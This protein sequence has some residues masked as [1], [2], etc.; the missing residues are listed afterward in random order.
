MVLP[1]NQDEAI[2]RFSAAFFLQPDE[3]CVLEPLAIKRKGISIEEQEIER[4]G[5][6]E[7]LKRK[8]IEEGVDRLTGGQHLKRRLEATYG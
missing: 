8:G 1:R 7:V 2:S 5:F 6:R 3:D 4:A